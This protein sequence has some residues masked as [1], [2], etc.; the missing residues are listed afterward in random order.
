MGVVVKY[1]NVH[2]VWLEN[3]QPFCLQH[4][5]WREISRRNCMQ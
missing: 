5:K 2:D 3:D 1:V 4:N